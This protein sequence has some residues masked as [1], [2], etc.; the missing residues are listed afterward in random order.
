MLGAAACRLGHGCSELVNRYVEVSLR[1]R[2]GMATN[3]ESV[4]LVGDE[5]ATNLA[6]AALFA[7]LVGAFAYVSFPFPVSPAPVTL[8]VLGVFLAGIFLGPRWGAAAMALYVFTGA[9]GVPVFAQGNAGLG[10][11]RGP[12]GGYLLSFPIAAAVIGLGVHRSTRV[13]DLRQI[14]LPWYA[15]GLAGGIATMYVLGGLWLS[16]VLEISI[17]KALVT[18]GLVF[19]PG[20]IAKA[21][22]AILAGRSGVVTGPGQA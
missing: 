2:S 17:P 13:T 20:D 1:V 19:L 15:F 22:A 10:Y 6:R 5:A 11:L 9:V 8:Q 16:L 7:A 12:T 18:G 3:T 14:G 4:D 21:I